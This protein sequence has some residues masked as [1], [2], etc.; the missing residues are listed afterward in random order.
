MNTVFRVLTDL[1]IRTFNVGSLEIISSLA[2]V[3][4]YFKV[5][6]QLSNIEILGRL[7]LLVHFLM[8]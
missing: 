2:V 1:N 5:R 4:K 6:F 7:W 8:L 3:T